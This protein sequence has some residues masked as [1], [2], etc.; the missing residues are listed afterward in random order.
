MSKSSSGS[1]KDQ[2]ALAH[3]DG[4]AALHHVLSEVL[5]QPWWLLSEV[6]ERSGFNEIQDVLLMNQAKRDTLTFLDANGVVTPLPQ[7]EKN[8]LLNVKLFSAYRERIGKPIIDWTK[9]TKADFNSIALYMEEEQ[10][11]IPCRTMGSHANAIQ[12]GYVP[13]TPMITVKHSII[14]KPRN[15]ICFPTV[16]PTPAIVKP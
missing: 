12:S 11:T 5:G 8:K 1:A 2:D 15:V 14:A 6:L 10:V 16:L 9:V 4:K 7:V 13:S 3:S